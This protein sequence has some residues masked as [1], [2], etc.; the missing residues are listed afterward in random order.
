M[1][2]SRPIA[3]WLISIVAMI[4]AMVVL[5]GLTRLTHSGLSIVEWKPLTGWLPPVG[6]SEWEEA[7]A[8]YRRFSH[9]QKNMGPWRPCLSCSLALA[10]P[11]PGRR[12]ARATSR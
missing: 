5:G 1:D 8:G 3:A 6:E 12:S 7:F 2:R 10:T 11:F 4:A 9:H